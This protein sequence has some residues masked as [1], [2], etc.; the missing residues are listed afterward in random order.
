MTKVA[1]CL[2]RF[3]RNCLTMHVDYLTGDGN[4]AVNRCFD[5][6]TIMGVRCGLT[7]H[8]LRS[9][10]TNIIRRYLSNQQLSH[11]R[12]N[13]SM[14]S[15]TPAIFKAKWI[16]LHL[17]HKERNRTV[18]TNTYFQRFHPGQYDSIFGAVISWIKWAGHQ[19]TVCISTPR[20]IAGEPI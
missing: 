19:H 20:A 2:S 10:M 14:H 5:D 3:I 4:L 7:H 11:L 6:Q 9:F 16:D 12:N 1:A 15:S 13:A 18:V 17:Q 8:Y